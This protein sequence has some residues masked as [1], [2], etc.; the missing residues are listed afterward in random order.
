MK[1]L[2]TLFFVLA[3]YSAT[4]QVYQLSQLHE[5]NDFSPIH[6]EVLPWDNSKLIQINRNF[7]TLGNYFTYNME[8]IIAGMA[9]SFNMPNCDI[10][11][12]D[13]MFTQGKV[14]CAGTNSNLGNELFMICEDSSYVYDINPGSQGSYPE[15]EK[16]ENVV[17]V[18]AEVNGVRQLFY[19]HNATHELI[20]I[21]EGNNNISRACGRFNGD[22]YY[23]KQ[24][25]DLVNDAQVFEL[26]RREYDQ[27]NWN[28]VILESISIPTG[29]F[30]LGKEVKWKGGYTLNDRIYFNEHIG[31]DF[32]QNNWNDY[33]ILS[34]TSSNQQG[35]HGAL[36]QTSP[37]AG[38]KMAG[39]INEV[40]YYRV[41][42]DTLFS[43]Q[44]NPDFSPSFISLTGTI[45][46][47]WMSGS[48]LILR[49][50]ISVDSSDIMNMSWVPSSLYANTHLHF[51]KA[52]G[53]YIYLLQHDDATMM[54]TVVV[55]KTFLGGGNI[56]EEVPVNV[57]IHAPY[58]DAALM[59]D[60]FF[61]FLSST[62]SSN[63]I[64][65]LAD[66]PQA[67][68]HEQSIDEINV[69]PNPVQSGEEISVI[70]KRNQIAQ[71]VSLSGEIIK[72]INLVKGDNKIDIS[73][74]E[75]GTYL[76]KA[77][78]E[79]HRVIIVN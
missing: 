69:Y 51:L 46:E 59:Y 63:N 53:Q 12:S 79:M 33:R 75:A 14:F 17:Y 34:Y 11:L 23:Q 41:G 65:Q 73:S 45:E 2:F 27:G 67:Q 44:F 8:S 38:V 10:I 13:P 4:S 49:R 36:Y 74:F 62:I 16:I 72:E 58:D 5:N 68:L 76:L 28:E 56:I 20:Q 24:W 43:T 50:K 70:S 37:Y 26:I 18:T 77:T 71:F 25:T 40:F 64:Y 21:T 52:Y 35:V 39:K 9:T 60:G 15:I 57:A 78:E 29:D 48:S 19:L 47:H 66:G 32:I 7:D 6:L 30:V 54:N 42:G 61:T 1:A 31:A 55:I 22:H 3:S